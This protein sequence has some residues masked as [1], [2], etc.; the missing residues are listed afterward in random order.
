MALAS[1]MR[2]SYNPRQ[3]RPND[4]ISIIAAPQSASQSLP[5]RSLPHLFPAVTSVLLVLERNPARLGFAWLE[6][7][8]TRAC[9]VPNAH[10]LRITGDE[11][12][13]LAKSESTQQPESRTPLPAK[14]PLPS[15]VASRNS[16]GST[17]YTVTMVIFAIF[18]LSPVSAVL[19]F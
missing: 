13:F 10:E 7:N 18:F 14:R 9:Q 4:L 8:P 3:T 16:S 11:L 19:E 12:R 5:P 17:V 2:L 1:C 15:R 6:R